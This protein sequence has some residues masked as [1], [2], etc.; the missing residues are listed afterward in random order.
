MEDLISR[1]PD[2]QPTCNQ[3]A[4]DCI[5]RQA[6][7]NALAKLVPYAIYDESTESYTNGLTDAHDLICLLPSA[8]PELTD[9]EKRLIKKLRSYHNG[10]YA[11]V[12]DKLLA[13]A[14]AQPETAHKVKGKVKAG[15]TLWYS[16]DHCERPVD[17]YDA[18]CHCCGRRFVDE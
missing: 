2:L 17:R 10:S 4:T 1:Q 9:E 14:S 5:S 3:L 11:K 12:I 7:I 8:Q 16:C 6:A 13:V 15:V 18:Y